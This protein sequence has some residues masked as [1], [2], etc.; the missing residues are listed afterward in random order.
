M[1]FLKETKVDEDGELNASSQSQTDGSSEASDLHNTAGS[2]QSQVNDSCL[3][4]AYK[5]LYLV[6]SHLQ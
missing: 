4:K 2:S 1:F 5:V 6:V 3:M